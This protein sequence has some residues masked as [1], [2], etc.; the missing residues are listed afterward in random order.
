[1][2]LREL[3]RVILAAIVVALLGVSAAV[4][5]PKVAHAST[6][7]S[8]TH[9]LG[10][11]AFPLNDLCVTTLYTVYSSS[12]EQIAEVIGCADVLGPAQSAYLYT[13]VDIYSKGPKVWTRS[14]QSLVYSYVGTDTDECVYY[15][16]WKS[17][18]PGD[19]GVWFGVW[20]VICGLT[21]NGC[22]PASPNGG[23]VISPGEWVDNSNFS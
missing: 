14:D 22:N 16:P 1:M 10:A 13:D 15:W 6:N 18:Q 2:S 9:C 12:N 3:W 8:V 4:V 17:V 11:A 20:G 5:T 19:V 7:K 23:T 21:D